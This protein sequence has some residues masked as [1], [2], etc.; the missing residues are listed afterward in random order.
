MVGALSNF[1]DDS[2]REALIVLR[3]SISECQ[4][5]S[6][7]GLNRVVGDA[8]AFAGI[9]AV[10]FKACVSVKIVPTLYGTARNFV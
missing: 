6:K 9:G 4:T 1:I 2:R 5:T 3:G 8:L 7:S 10:V